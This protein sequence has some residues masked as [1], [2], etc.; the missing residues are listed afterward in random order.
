MN[1]GFDGFCNQVFDLFRYALSIR[2]Y[3]RGFSWDFDSEWNF[4]CVRI[5]VYVY[6]CVGD[7]FM[8]RSL[9]KNYKL[10]N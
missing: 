10:I 2:G 3:C 4:V 5:Y 8:V 9:R 7:V 1:E 6:E